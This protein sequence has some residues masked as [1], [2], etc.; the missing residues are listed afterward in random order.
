M[1]LSR[2]L[3][4]TQSVYNGS[5]FQT[6][7]TLHRTTIRMPQDV[8]DHSVIDSF[9]LEVCREGVLGSLVR[10]HPDPVKCL[11]A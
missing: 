9:S 8:L 5:V 11:L 2:R 1:W 4:Q 3:F 6:G 7:I 10:V